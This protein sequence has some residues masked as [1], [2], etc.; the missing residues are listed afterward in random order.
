MSRHAQRFQVHETA[1]SSPKSV[2]F[3]LRDLTQS[4]LC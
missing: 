2:A 3:T 4:R 1:C